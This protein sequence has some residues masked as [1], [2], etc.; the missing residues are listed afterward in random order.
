M[1]IAG[2][3]LLTLIGVVLL[4]FDAYHSSESNDDS[5]SKKTSSSTNNNK[6]SVSIREASLIGV[7]LTLTNIGTGVGAGILRLNAPLTAFCSSATRYIFENKIEF[8]TIYVCL[9]F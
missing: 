4:L 2:Y 5:M 1:H 9:V 3:G 8:I 6:S 7:S